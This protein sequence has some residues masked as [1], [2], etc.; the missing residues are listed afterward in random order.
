MN[1]V[2]NE[3]KNIQRSGNADVIPEKKPERKQKPGGRCLLLLVLT[4]LAAL[5]A[6]LAVSTWRSYNTL[7]VNQY[8]YT[9]EKVG[10]P[11]RICVLSDLHDHSFG[12]ENSRLIKQVLETDPDLIIMAGDMLNEDSGDDTI[13]VTLVRSLRA[14]MNLED[15]A[16]AGEAVNREDTAGTGETMNREDTAG[17]GETMNRESTAGSGETAIYYALGNAEM[18]F[19]EQHPEIDLM[20]DLK[21]AGAEVLE[22]TMQDLNFAAPESSTQ[23]S[24]AAARSAGEAD[25]ADESDFVVP[26]A[27]STRIRLGG[28]YAYPFG[29]D[30]NDSSESA[31]AEVRS[32]LD[33]F[34]D[35]DALKI[36][37]AHRPESFCFGDAAEVRDIDLVISGHDHGGQVILPFIGGLYAGDQG[38]FPKYVHGF[39]RIGGTE[40]F[41]TSGLGSGRELLPRFNNPPEIAVIDILPES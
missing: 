21:E 13:P 19:M 35:T 34:E 1:Q 5:L 23:D 7:Q 38:F 24:E 14:A 37:A 28:L 41:V 25:D 40:L 26:G 32:Y 33:D 30:G 20:G 3:E 31:P 27:E 2:R 29:S 36:L 18:A 16:G 6:L 8:E 4:A 22:S 12:E 17:T 39:Y 10:V 9:S 15:T 11:L